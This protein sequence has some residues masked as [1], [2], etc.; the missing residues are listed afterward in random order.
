MLCDLSNLDALWLHIFS[1]DTYIGYL[2]TKIS[3][4]AN[5]LENDYPFLPNIPM[6]FPYEIVFRN[7]WS[8]KNRKS[9]MYL[10]KYFLILYAKPSGH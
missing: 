3:K 1:H 7:Y 2:K 10:D 8:D 4:T 9:D 5:T 6:N